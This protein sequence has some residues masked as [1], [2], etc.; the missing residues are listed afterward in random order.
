LEQWSEDKGVRGKKWDSKEE[1]WRWKGNE[2]IERKK[3]SPSL[4]LPFT[5]T[6][7]NHCFQLFSA[8]N[9]RVDILFLVLI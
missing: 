2:W 4:Q 8:L 3:V 6:K 7:V 9:L 5:T 1:Q